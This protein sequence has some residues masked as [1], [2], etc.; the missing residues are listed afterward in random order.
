MEPTEITDSCELSFEM[1]G[2]EAK[3]S[4]GADRVLNC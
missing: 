1:Q 3:A 4:G 2:I